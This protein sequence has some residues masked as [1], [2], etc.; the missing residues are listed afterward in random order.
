MHANI[1]L[2]NLE[3]FC[4]KHWMYLPCFWSFITTP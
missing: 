2:K 4:G 3:H 1:L